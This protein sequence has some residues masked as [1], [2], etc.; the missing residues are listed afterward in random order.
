MYTFSHHVNS[1]L[2]YVCGRPCTGMYNN[3]IKFFVETC[4]I[5]RKTCEMSC[6]GGPSV[7][8]D[9]YRTTVTGG[10]GGDPNNIVGDLNVD[11]DI[12]LPTAKKLKIGTT[13]YKA[14]GVVYNTAQAVITN[15]DADIRVQSATGLTLGAPL[16]TVRNYVDT[17]PGVINSIVEVASMS[18]NATYELDLDPAAGTVI[19]NS[20]QST[21]NYLGTDDLWRGVQGSCWEYY[22]G[23][24]VTVT[25]PQVITNGVNLVLRNNALASDT[26]T[27]QGPLNGFHFY[28]SGSADP[29]GLITPELLGDSYVLGV[30][31]TA[32]S[33]VTTGAVDLSI[34]L[35]NAIVVDMGVVT[36]PKGR[37]I[38]HTFDKTINLFVGSSFLAGGGSVMLQSISGNTTVTDVA[39]LIN[40]IHTGRGQDP[41]TFLIQ[42]ILTVGLEN[43]DFIVTTTPNPVTVGEYAFDATGVSWQTKANSFVGGFPVTG[44]FLGGVNCE[45]LK[46]QFPSRM[47]ISTYRAYFPNVSGRPKRWSI[48]ISQDNI[49]WTIVHTFASGETDTGLVALNSSC[50]YIAFC[51]EETN[52]G[53]SAYVSTLFFNGQLL[54][55]IPQLSSVPNPD[56]LVDSSSNYNPTFP[57]WRAFDWIN[58]PASQQWVSGINSYNIATGAYAGVLGLGTFTGEWVKMAF[59][60]LTRVSSFRMY[61]SNSINDP[62]RFRVLVSS[63][64]VDWESIH[65]NTTVFGGDTGIVTFPQP[66]DCNHIA[67]LV[68]TLGATNNGFTGITE[69]LYA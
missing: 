15:A 32:S 65:L 5:I 30:R 12:C 59:T 40:R 22:H 20:D 1:G 29:A 17:G 42:P 62:L 66:H 53:T 56:Y 52:G 11:G 7:A 49:T 27:S 64:G 57:P 67:V 50:R 25:N 41:S 51:V 6:C 36:F 45:Y 8:G 68:E 69:I 9:Q 13:E 34:L 14:E 43:P 44:I 4:V 24:S 46:V 26:N 35:D 38:S 21:L 47:Y 48:M 31:F 2:I 23:S 37:N 16:T 58:L 61:G 3:K 19:F 54:S 18:T 39:F 33:S 10:G 28:T 55:E 60:T 63:D